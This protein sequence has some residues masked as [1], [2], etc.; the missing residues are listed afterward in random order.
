MNDKD[1]GKW[2]LLGG[3]SAN[4]QVRLFCLPVGG[5]G[6]SQYMSWR[7][8]L[9]A[10]VDLCLLQLPGR[11]GR[12]AEPPINEL[13]VLIASIIEGIRPLMDLPFCIFGHSLGAV[14]GF[15]LA[16]QLRARL[17]LDPVWIGISGHPA[18]CLP[19]RRP[20]VSHLDREEFRIAMGRDFD[21]SDFVLQDKELFD[22][23]YPLLRSDFGIVETYECEESAPFRCIGVFGGDSDPEASKSELEA[24]K[25][26][27]IEPLKLTM[28]PGGHD[29]VQRNRMTITR[30]LGSEILRCLGE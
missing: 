4:R 14:V 10:A 8:Q 23:I 21:V 11:D 18:P 20:K 27:S 12:A 1:A 7:G 22:T 17:G 24:W 6:C 16:R 25:A 5:G 9:P 28:L 29:F 13:D 19:R 3:D 2:L 26:Y 30:I 15:E